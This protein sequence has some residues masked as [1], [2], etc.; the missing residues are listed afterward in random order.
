MVS[1]EFK[2]NLIN[3]IKKIDLN[4]KNISA[5]TRIYKFEN[6]SKNKDTICM[7]LAGYKEFTWDIVFKRI[8]EFSNDDIDICI[9]S[10]GLYSERLS[11]IAKINGWSYLSTKRNCVTLAQNMVLKLFPNAN[12]I[13][14]LDEDIFITKHFFKTL[15]TTFDE[16]QKKGEYNVGFIAPI[17]PINGYCHVV[18]LKKLGLVEYYEQHF[19]KVKYAA[20]GD[21]MIENNVDVARFMWGENNLIPHI[22]DLDKLLNDSEF[23]YSASTVRFSIG[24]ILY[25]RQLWKDMHYFKVGVTKGMGVDEVQICEF[26]ITNSKA[27][28]VSENTCAGHLS[29]GPQNNMME[30]FYKLHQD[31]FSIKVVNDNE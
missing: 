1:N 8:K 30:E 14:K 2:V 27:M 10:S 11:K 5:F 31:N 24:A 17:L 4:I 9:V 15:K 26:C 16:V 6:R 25:T 23:S 7:I 19:E 28:V 21:R 12:Y 29:F 3:F 20:G 22:D 13:F 18:L